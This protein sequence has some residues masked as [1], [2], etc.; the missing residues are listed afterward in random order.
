MIKTL[1]DTVKG[2]RET[3]LREASVSNIIQAL[4]KCNVNT[5]WIQEDP[6]LEDWQNKPEQV[7]EVMIGDTEHEVSTSVQK[8]AKYELTERLNLVRDLEK[9][10]R[11]AR[12]TNHRCGVRAGP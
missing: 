12:R 7:E 5:M 11:D 4:Q 2:L 1:E 3:S 10:H 8:F 9:R 6:E